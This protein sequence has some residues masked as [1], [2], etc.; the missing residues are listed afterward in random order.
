MKN[1][2]RTFRYKFFITSGKIK[3]L[4]LRGATR[5]DLKTPEK[6]TALRIRKFSSLTAR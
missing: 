5:L 3:C 1:L 6:D 2:I 4:Y